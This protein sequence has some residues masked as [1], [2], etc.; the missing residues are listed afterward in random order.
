MKNNFFRTTVIT[1]LLAST[2]F[3]N[4]NSFSVQNTQ[5]PFFKEF[6][7]MQQIF[8]RLHNDFFN[9]ANQKIYN[10]EFP[11]VNIQELKNS[12]IIKFELA[13]INKKDIKV[14]IKDNKYLIVEGERKTKTENKN[15]KTVVNEFFYGTFQRVLNLPKDANT[16]KMNLQFKNAILTVNIPKVKNFQ[17]KNIRILNIN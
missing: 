17:N 7:Q 14:Y 9:N 12:Y 8:Q 2:L 4:T 6:N 13:G 1:T 3:A 16:K 15:N 5:D 10:D 11:R